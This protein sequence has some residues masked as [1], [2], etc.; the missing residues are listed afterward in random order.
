[1]SSSFNLVDESWL[2]VVMISGESKKVSLIDFFKFLDDI[3]EF[4]GCQSVRISLLHFILT[5]SHAALKPKNSGEI[6]LYLS[7]HNKVKEN[8]IN[9]L[10]EHKDCFDLYSNDKPFLQVVCMEIQESENTE[11]KGKNKVIVK[12]YGNKEVSLLK[13]EGQNNAIMRDDDF[14]EQFLSDDEKALWLIV[15]QI[16]G[17]NAKYSISEKSYNGPKL[18]DRNQNIVD[19]IKEITTKSSEAFVSG[20]TK[21]TEVI[22][23]YSKDMYST[24]ILN[25]VSEE[26]IKRYP[27]KWGVPVWEIDTN[28][29][30]SFISNMRDVCGSFLGRLT[31]IVKFIRFIPNSQSLQYSATKGYDYNDYGEA[32]KKDGCSYPYFIN[33]PNIKKKSLLKMYEP[34]KN[35]WREFESFYNISNLGADI[36]KK[37]GEKDVN[38]E[39]VWVDHEDNVVRVIATGFELSNSMG[40]FY[41]KKELNSFIPCKIKLLCDLTMSDLKTKHLN[42]VDISDNM[43]TKLQSAFEVFAKNTGVSRPPWHFLGRYWMELDN[44]SVW[45]MNNLK[46]ENIEKLWQEKVFCAARDTL[47]SLKSNDTRTMKAISIAYKTLIKTKGKV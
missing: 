15:S 8:C 45:M 7:K 46:L 22:H 9:Y 25:M 32:M 3:V 30:N 40:L 34:Q 43:F 38:G 11:G 33:E 1:M 6:I 29:Y 14:K 24:L 10:L 36:F 27:K 41:V 23:I 13:K 21:S 42:N 18:Y 5:I 16:S 37:F 17:A 28:D 47:F 2:P 26:E 35:L 20:S 12:K 39:N 44:E 19:Q 4:K 31:P